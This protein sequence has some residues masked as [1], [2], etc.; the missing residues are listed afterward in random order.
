MFWVGKQVSQMWC[1]AKHEKW[2]WGLGMWRF[3]FLSEPFSTVWLVRS[4]N[5]LMENETRTNDRFE[6]FDLIFVTQCS[7]IRTCVYLLEPTYPTS[8]FSKSWTM[9]AFPQLHVDVLESLDSPDWSFQGS[10]WRHLFA[11]SVLQFFCL[12]FSWFTPEGSLS[13]VS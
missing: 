7:Y 8:N 11:L 13:P 5:A 10:L 3:C 6:G 4:V 12:Y 2:L 1:P 9:Y